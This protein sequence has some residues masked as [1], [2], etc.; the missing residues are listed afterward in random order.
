MDK[1]NKSPSR[2][3][4]LR[5][6]VINGALLSAIPLGVMGSQS[7][8]AAPAPVKR[9]KGPRLPLKI[10]LNTRGGQFYR[11]PVGAEYRD[12]ILSISP[13]ISMTDDQADISSVNAWYGPI[14]SDQLKAAENLLWVHSTSAGVERYPLQEM[15]EGDVLLTNCK[16]CFAPSIAEHAFGML[17]AL[18]HNI[19]VQIKNMN[20]GKWQ[21]VPMEEVFELKKWT[22]GVIGLGGIGSQIARRARAMDMKVIA[23]D[24]VP[25][26]KEQIGDICDELR[27]VQDD[28]LSWLFSNA[29]VIV[30]CAPHTKAS[31]GMIGS[32]Q[33]NLMKKTAYFMNVSRGK[34][35]KTPDLVAALKAG[36]MAGACLDVTDPEPLPADH[37]LWTFPN[38][39][40]TSHISAR[41]QYNRSRSFEVWVENVKRFA[42]GWP[43]L[44]MVDL[45]LG[46]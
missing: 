27:L 44:N 10:Y 42:N 6:A 29:D 32:A 14:N 5:G 46:F 20:E 17:F 9:A 13:D 38:V 19:G 15:L 18:T 23:V 33:F 2:R 39:I 11:D 28:G 45:E 37:E 7:A 22:M 31:E 40:I 4:F 21:N 35:V 43:M 16:G 1:T 26:Y 25:K 34:L 30:S 36:N 3:E 41:S 12:Q 8:T 24:I